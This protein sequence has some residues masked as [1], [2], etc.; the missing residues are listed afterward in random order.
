M[1]KEGDNA[2]RKRRDG[3]EDMQKEKKLKSRI[4]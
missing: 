3:K 1:N 4:I 2:R